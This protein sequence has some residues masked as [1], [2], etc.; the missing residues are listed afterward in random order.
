[1]KAAL[2][3][4]ALGAAAATPLAFHL[5]HEHGGYLHLAAFVFC[6]FAV[7]ET[8]GLLIQRW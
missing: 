6:L 7:R 1:M 2:L 4:T 3:C 5:M 8:V